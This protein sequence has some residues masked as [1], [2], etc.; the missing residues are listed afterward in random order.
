VERPQ[1]PYP[2][3]A[4]PLSVRPVPGRAPVA[5][6]GGSGCPSA[7]DQRA[8]VLGGHPL[9][10]QLFEGGVHRRVDALGVA[11][12]SEMVSKSP[13]SFTMIATTGCD[14]ANSRI[15]R[16]FSARNRSPS[17]LGPTIQRA[18]AVA[19]PVAHPGRWRHR[20]GVNTGSATGTAL[21]LP[22]QHATLWRC[23]GPARGPSDPPHANAA[24]HPRSPGA[25]PNVR[26]DPAG[27]P[28]RRWRDRRGC[29]PGRRLPAAGRRVGGPDSARRWRPARTDQHPSTITP[30]E[31]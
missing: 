19:G 15:S 11:V 20:P 16:W 6:G 26:G 13:C 10:A 3:S 18:G 17:P 23:R 31:G 2:D 4:W 30:I 25:A 28:S 29:R 14:F 27:S 5:A 21:A 9:D 1:Y 8:G 24:A 12:V 22:P 7:P